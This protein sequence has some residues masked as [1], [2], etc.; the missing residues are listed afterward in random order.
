MTHPK[1]HL[2][3]ATLPIHSWRDYLH[4]K[5]EAS[6]HPD[7]Y[8][9]EVA[10][11]KISWGKR[12]SQVS[13]CDFREAK[14]RWFVGATLNVAENCV[15]RHVREGRGHHTAIDF[16]GN[17]S[18]ERRTYSFAQLK[19]EVCRVANALEAVG[20]KKGDRVV[21]YLPHIPELAFAVL[22]CARIGAIH[23]VIFGGF[24][25]QSIHNRVVDCSAKVILT[26]NGT[27]RGNKWIELKARVDEAL[28]MGCPSVEKVITLS[29]DP[30]KPYSKGALD[31]AWEDWVTAT[32]SKEHFPIPHQAEDPLFILYTSGSTGKPKG[33]LHA[34][35]GYLTYVA[36]THE[37]VF[38]IRP[39]DVFWCTAD[40]GWI[41]G[42][43]YVLYGPLA[44]GITT[45]LFEG[46]P[47][48]PDPG[49]YWELIERLGVTIFYT[50]PTAIRMLASAGEEYTK[51]GNRTSLRVL[52]TVGEPI[53]PEVWAW[54]DKTIGESRC[55]IVDTWWQTETGGILLSPLAGVSRTKPGSACFP[56]PGVEPQVVD[57]SGKEILDDAPG[58]L[59]IRKSWP[60]QM[61]GIYGDKPGKEGRFY[62]TYFQLF[63][64]SYW[65]GDGA[66]RD[67]DGCYWI[68]GRTDDVIK[69]SGHRLGSAEIESACITHPLVAES[70]AIGVPDA[71][72][73]E[74][75]HVFA[76]LK[77]PDSSQ[78]D[79][80]TFTQEIVQTVRREV[81][82]LAHPS[83][84]H[85]VPGLPKTRSGKIMRRLLKK[86][87]RGEF[88][89]LG[90]TSTLAEP[91]IVERLVQALKDRK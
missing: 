38:Q 30:N 3:A 36:H 69:V 7:L 8:W 91:Q 45:V 48:F 43:S 31:L 25:A 28:S 12:W 50:A 62:Q 66:K 20:V 88:D 60:G 40:M 61:I 51:K 39:D 32:T 80:T 54:Y 70:A 14:V 21:L 33:V 37:T 71:M 24:S 34:M 29:R 11:R 9:A 55:P 49:V 84:V 82:P 85:L 1:A 13:D 18:R 53:N 90:D 41:T 5:Q 15:D 26:A 4:Q 65:T 89:T 83:R 58:T 77:N 73:G 27:H 16:V 59:L 72:T 63:E 87:A 81:G 46:V 35:G 42:H 57:E 47:N 74:A 78:P 75:I 56:L 2:K 68:L 6:E 64:N 44:N 10:Q 23:S 19:D 17:D 52:G 67:P 76:V 22:A 79:E 86:L